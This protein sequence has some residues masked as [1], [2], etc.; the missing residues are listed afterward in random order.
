MVHSP[1]SGP[2]V[3]IAGWCQDA[4][5]DQSQGDGSWWPSNLPKLWWLLCWYHHSKFY[6]CHSLFLSRSTQSMCWHILVWAFVCMCL[7]QLSVT[8]KLS[9][10]IVLCVMYCSLTSMMPFPWKIRGAGITGA[11]TNKNMSQKFALCSL[12]AMVMTLMNLFWL[13]VGTDWNDD[14]HAK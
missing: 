13:G 11:M 6:H 14:W 8:D 2:G 12:A 5:T 7:F 3:N 9:D 4:N 1:L 10:G